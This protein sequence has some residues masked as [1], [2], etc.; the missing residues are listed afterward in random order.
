MAFCIENSAS[1]K[2]LFEALRGIAWIDPDNVQFYSAEWFWQ[3]QVN[4]YALQVEPDGFKHK[5]RVLLD[6]KDALYIE[7]IRN[8]FFVELK[9][10]LRDV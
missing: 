8:K 6:Y 4:S 1:G 10:L 9:A 3:R 5:D 7:K 2:T